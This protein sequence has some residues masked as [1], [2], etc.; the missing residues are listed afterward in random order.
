MVYEQALAAGGERGDV[1]ARMATVAGRDLGDLSRSI[2]GFEQALQAGAT[3][4]W[5]YR[6]LAFALLQAG[7]AEQAR[8]VLQR[9]LE[10]NPRSADLHREMAAVYE[11]EGDADRAAFHRQK[12]QELSAS[13]P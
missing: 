7:R 2:D 10:A 5:I 13:T 9:G 11:R 8:S 3:A 6:N 4:P 12:A 1:L